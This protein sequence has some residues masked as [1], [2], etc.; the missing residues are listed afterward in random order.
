MPPRACREAPRPERV[1]SNRRALPRSTCAWG[2]SRIRGCSP[3]L[4]AETPPSSIRD[5]AAPVRSLAPED[6]PDS[7]G[8][9]R[10]AEA[11]QLALDAAVSPTRVLAHES[12]DQRAQVVQRRWTAWATMRIRPAACDQLPMPAPKRRGH[13]QERRPGSPR[14]RPA[15]RREQRPISWPKLWTRD[16][17]LEHLQLVT[18]HEDLDLLLTLRPHPQHEQLQQ[19]PHRPVQERPHR[20]PRTTHLDRRP[21]TRH[22]QSAGAG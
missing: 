11:D 22:A 12:Q 1:R 18:K 15:E 5:A 13:H 17:A 6:L 16:L 20:A 8:S 14:Q 3:P 21:Y 10:D 2:G 4:G 19:A 9:K 7:A